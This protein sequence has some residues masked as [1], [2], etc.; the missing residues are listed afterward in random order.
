LKAIKHFS[1][2]GQYLSKIDVGER[3]VD[4]ICFIDSTRLAVCYWD[5]VYVDIMD[6]KG[7]ILDSCRLPSVPTA[8]T[9]LC[10]N[11]GLLY[12]LFYVYYP[13]SV[14]NPDGQYRYV[15]IGYSTNGRLLAKRLD[16][17]ALWAETGGSYYTGSADAVDEVCLTEILNAAGRT[18]TKSSTDSSCMFEPL[19]VDGEDNLYLVRT[20]RDSEKKFHYVVTKFSQCGE[21]RAKFEIRLFYPGMGH[22]AKLDSKGNVYVLVPPEGTKEWSIFKY[23]PTGRY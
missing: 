2:R 8:M 7:Q 23:S 16:S 21:E 15:G 14:W 3:L 17:L 11:K 4:D 19:G 18:F 20:I 12:V 5:R 1:Q 22:W 13:D 10:V 9:Y 6:F